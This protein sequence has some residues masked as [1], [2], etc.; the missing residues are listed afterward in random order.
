MSFRNER[1]R[2]DHSGEVGGVNRFGNEQACGNAAPGAV[3]GEQMVARPLP[4]GNF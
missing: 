1:E 4:L 3:V 2:A